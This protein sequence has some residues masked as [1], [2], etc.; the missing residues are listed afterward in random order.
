MA[1][2]GELAASSA[3]EVNQPL[4]ESSVTPVLD[5]VCSIAAMSSFAE[6]R[7]LLDDI[8]ADGRRAGDVIRGIQSMVKRCV[9]PAA[10]ESE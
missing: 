8:V 5:G 4:S 10:G 6:L 7:D 1:A 3:H 2:V 9:G